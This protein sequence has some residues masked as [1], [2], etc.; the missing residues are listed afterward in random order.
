MWDE[1]KRE[2]QI[3]QIFTTRIRPKSAALLIDI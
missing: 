1:D 3:A 2:E